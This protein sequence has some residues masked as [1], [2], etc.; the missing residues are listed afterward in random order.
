MIKP[1]ISTAYR[2]LDNPQDKVVGVVLQS[3]NYSQFNL[4]QLNRNIDEP[5]VLRLQKALRKDPSLT[6]EPIL[7]DKNMNIVD[8]QHRFLALSTLN[9]PI[10][11]MIDNNIS[12]ND[13]SEL[14][15]N[16]K[17]WSLFDYVQ[18]FVN[19]GNQNY[20][21][22]QH[23]LD[24]FKSVSTI[25]VIAQ[26]FGNSKSNTFGGQTNKVIKE[27]KYT[28]DVSKQIEME[29]FF[30]FITQIQNAIPNKRKL[31]NSLQ[32]AVKTWYLNPQVDRNRLIKVLDIDMIQMSPRNS[33][34]CAK[35]IGEK[36]NSRLKHKINYSIDN[37]GHFSFI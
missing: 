10:T 6:F 16:Q 13:A 9:K 30:N 4:N 32:Q 35:A 24:K 5:H 8:G 20:L 25:S 34:T 2:F 15:S 11:Y 18:F 36:Y 21:F 7:V 14:N 29:G 37:N 26:S 1:L 27:G 3:K 31:S 12:I 22:L 28:F 17:N 19:K 33:G 23:E